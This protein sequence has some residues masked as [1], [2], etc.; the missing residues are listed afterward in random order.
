MIASSTDWTPKVIR[1]LVTAVGLVSLSLGLGGCVGTP[2]VHSLSG[3]WVATGAPVTSGFHFDDDG[4]FVG[5]SIPRLL[6]LTTRQLTWDDA[7]D[8][9]G[10][11]E[12]ADTPGVQG[13]AIDVHFEETSASGPVST[14]LQFDGTPPDL[15]FVGAD[16]DLQVRFTREE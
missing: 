12:W 3:D 2:E 7:V 11:W 6:L 5:T 15:L 1:A 9:S 13:Q 4:T 10:T 14:I 8:V 16:E